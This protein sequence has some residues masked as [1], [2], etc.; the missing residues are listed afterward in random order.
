MPQV[1]KA[2]AESGHPIK[3]VIFLDLTEPE[4]WRRFEESKIEGDRG[5]RTDDRQ[6]IIKNRLDKY[7][8]RTLPVIDFYR[9]KNLL[10]KVNGSLERDEVTNEILKGLLKK[11]NKLKR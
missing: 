9:D 2:A 1:I 4:V 10:I 7:K 8:T 3:A 11:S 6:E 5:K